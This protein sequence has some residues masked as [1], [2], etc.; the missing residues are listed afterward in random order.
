MFLS[1]LKQS[2]FLPNQYAQDSKSSIV[3]ETGTYDFDCFSVDE[4]STIQDVLSDA[5]RNYSPRYRAIG[6]ALES[7]GILYKPRYILHEIIIIRYSSS[8]RPLD[9]LA[10]GLAYKTKGAYFRQQAIKYIENAIP[11]IT[12]REWHKISAFFPKWSIYNDLSDLC[13]AECRFSDA[14]EYAELAKRNKGF[15]A[16][17]DILHPGRIYKKIDIAL[18]VQYYEN[19]IC[20]N[21]TA[22]Y[23][24]LIEKELTIAKGQAEQGYKYRPRKSKMSDRSKMLEEKTYAAA[25]KFM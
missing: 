23:W 24:P 20:N 17:Y 1:K 5:Q 13:E 6:L 7:Y 12:K 4:C 14:L 11:M 3:D 19:L 16:P 8:K 21:Q 18:C 25:L 15:I 2:P 22:E 10:V 9:Q